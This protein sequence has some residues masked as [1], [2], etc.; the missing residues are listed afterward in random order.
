M[1][2]YPPTKQAY[3]ALLSILRIVCRSFLHGYAGRETT[4]FPALALHMYRS[5]TFRIVPVAEMVAQSAKTSCSLVPVEEDEY[6]ATSVMP[7]W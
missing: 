3:D 5:C 2:T 1:D 6:K 7:V 4:T